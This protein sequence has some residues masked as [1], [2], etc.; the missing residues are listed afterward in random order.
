MARWKLRNK[1]NAGSYYIGSGNKVS[2]YTHKPR[3]AFEDIR[4][5]YNCELD[6]PKKNN[7][8][9]EKFTAEEMLIAR[10]NVVNKIRKQQQKEIIK[11]IAALIISLGILFL[12]YQLFLLL[13]EYI[14]NF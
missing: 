12:L 7:N 11:K 1:F 8:K 3:P 14:N 9:P 13:M 4:D 2:T 6:K 10:K 5:K